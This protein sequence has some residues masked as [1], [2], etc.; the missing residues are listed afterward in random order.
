M[1]R[2]LLPYANTQTL[3]SNLSARYED[4]Q[5]FIARPE[6]VKNYLIRPASQLTER[7]IKR[8][9]SL[10]SITTLQV[11]MTG[12]KNNFQDKSIFI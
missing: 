9:T 3:L 11:Y 12:Y 10:K 1:Y 2:R 5:D 4:K 8:L 6:L 7:I